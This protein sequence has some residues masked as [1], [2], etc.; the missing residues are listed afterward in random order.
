MLR[1][2]PFKYTVRD[3]V[4]CQNIADCLRRLIKI[5]AL[6]HCNSTPEGCVRMVAISATPRAMTTEIEMALAEDEELTEVRKRCKTRDWSSAPNPYNFLRDEITVVGRLVMRGIRIVMP[7]C[8][9][10]RVL[11][12][13]HEGHQGIVKTIDPLRSKL[14]WPAMNAMVEGIA[15]KALGSRR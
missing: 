7:L 11:E 8:L 13:A 3:V 5:L 12:L 4:S 6:S 10:E 2:M 9:R 1:L 14:W 15:R